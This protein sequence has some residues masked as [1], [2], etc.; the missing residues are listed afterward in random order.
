MAE[1][2]PVGT[3][4]TGALLV[5]EV[6]VT[7]TK[8]DED[9]GVTS[10]LAVLEELEMLDVDSGVVMVAEVE[11]CTPVEVEIGEEVVEVM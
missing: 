8:V 4:D 3:S 10:A 1:S 7:S 9:V 5:V 2:V 6:V 11:D